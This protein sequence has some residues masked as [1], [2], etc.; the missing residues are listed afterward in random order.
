MPNSVRRSLALTGALV[1]ALSLGAEPA[2]IGLARAY[3]GPDSSLDSI[4]SIHFKGVLDRVDP[5]HPDTVVDHATL[6]MI[7]AKPSR[8][9][10]IITG[11]KATE[12]TV[13]D[14]YEAWDFLQDSADPT[15]HVLTWLKPDGVRSL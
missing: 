11:K 15:R 1:G 2:V 6:D 12:I 5:D 4:Q 14:G 7:V 3:L 8:Q 13:L 9:R 10:Q